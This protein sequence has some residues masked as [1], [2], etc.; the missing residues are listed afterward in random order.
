[1]RGGV[2]EKHR[3]EEI[4]K[5]DAIQ[6]AAAEQFGR[7]SHRYGKGHI[8]ADISDVAA[9]LK[10]IPLS[11]PARVLDVATGA[12]HTGLHCASLGHEVVCA[13]IAQP[14]LDRVNESA[15]ERGLEVETRRHPAEALPY[16]DARFDLVTSRVAPHHFSSPQ[17]FV[18]E[19]A[20]VLRPGG[21][22][23]LID[24]SIE[25]GDPVAEEWTHQVEKLRDPSHHRFLSPT[26]WSSLC[27]AAGLTITFAALEPFQMP[28]LEW[29][30]DTANTSSTNRKLVR[31]LVRNAPPEARQQFRIEEQNNQITWWWRRLTLIARKLES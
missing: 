10:R 14:M 12:G 9:A 16:E 2:V 25:D 28:D 8:L 5:L 4:V 18:E 20:R 21:H 3:G 11:P 17:A 23:M 26:A 7:Q 1:M 15:R 6:N 30:F 19:T 29:Y 31:E 22:F 13:D 27:D 24:G